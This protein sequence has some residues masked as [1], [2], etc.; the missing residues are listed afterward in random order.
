MP[1]RYSGHIPDLEIACA[2]LRL[3]HNA[4]SSS[5]SADSSRWTS[6]RLASPVVA[7]GTPA[8]W[9]EAATAS[10]SRVTRPGSRR[11]QWPGMAWTRF[12]FCAC[13]PQKTDWIR[14]WCRRSVPT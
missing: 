1:A 13:W 10:S 8:V 11:R 4:P 3:G 12:G 5:A 7:Y 6:C 14:R 9:H 2:L